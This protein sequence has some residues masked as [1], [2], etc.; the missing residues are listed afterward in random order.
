MKTKTNALIIK[1]R[2]PWGGMEEAGGAWSN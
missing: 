2:N 1:M